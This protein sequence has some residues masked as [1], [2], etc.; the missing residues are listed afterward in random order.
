M[1]NVIKHRGTVESIK[2]SHLRVRILQTSACSS[3]SAKGHCNAAES[4]EKLID[5]KD[6]AASSYQVGQSVMI[7]GATS[8]GMQAVWLAF[9]VP[10]FLLVATLFLAMHFTGGDEAFSALAALAVLA[11]Y[12]LLIYLCKNRLAKRFRFTITPIEHQ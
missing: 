10:F 5:I 1:T 9:G 12:Y 2:G 3:C 4:K 11:P 6:T 7:V 8:M